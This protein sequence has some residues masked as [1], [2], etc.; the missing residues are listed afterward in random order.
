MK[1]QKKGSVLFLKAGLISCLLASL[2]HAPVQ[3]A[4]IAGK[5]TVTFTNPVGPNTMVF[6]GAGTNVFSWG[7]PASFGVG[8]NKLSFTGNNFSANFGTVF[9]IGSLSYFN[10]TTAFGTNP[11]SV[12]LNTLLNFTIPSST[13]TTTSSFK[14]T[15]N[16]TDN[17]GTDVQNADYVNFVNQNAS[18]SMTINGVTYAIKMTGFSNVIGDG[19]LNSTATEF[20]VMEGKTASADL[21]GVVSV[22][23]V[24]EPESY[25]M[26]LSGLGLF[27]V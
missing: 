20:H 19:Y 14:M 3:A 15:L 13:S 6:S 25:L 21:F 10:G 7:D 8:A 4:D 5:S 17:T 1:R 2:V 16:S 18:T 9:K 11:T 12:D 26:L 24:P 27:A 23:A 22:S